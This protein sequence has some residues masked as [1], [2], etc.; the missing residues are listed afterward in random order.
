LGPGIKI[1]KGNAAVVDDVVT[2]REDQNNQNII[3]TV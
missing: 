3:I 1:S 2:W